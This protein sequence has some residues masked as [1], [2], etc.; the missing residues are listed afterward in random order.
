MTRQEIADNMGLQ[1][2]SV[3]GRV[4]EL[5]KYGTAYE[6]GMRLTKWGKKAMIVKAKEVET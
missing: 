3:C 4:N 1:I 6:E 2:N 5:I